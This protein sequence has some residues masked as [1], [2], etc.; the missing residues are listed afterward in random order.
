MWFVRG[1]VM[2]F[3]KKKSFSFYIFN[4]NIGTPIGIGKLVHRLG[5]EN[6]N[7]PIGMYVMYIWY[8]YYA[9]VLLMNVGFNSPPIEV[10]QLTD[11][12]SGSIHLLRLNPYGHKHHIYTYT[13]LL[14][15]AGCRLLQRIRITIRL[16]TL[17]QHFFNDQYKSIN[18]CK[19]KILNKIII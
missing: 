9:S 5:Q 12:T 18:L 13:Y 3:K 19:E 8:P 2:A 17:F 1:I 11:R 10:I 7:F 16:P 14:P 4:N 6:W 15:S